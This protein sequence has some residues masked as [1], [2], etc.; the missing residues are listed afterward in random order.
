[1]LDGFYVNQKIFG[2]VILINL[3]K[4]NESEIGIFL[5]LCK[6]KG[7][8]LVS[9]SLDYVNYNEDKCAEINEF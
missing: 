5:S 7:V 2:S 6:L 9:F 8:N 1:M 3:C 4:L